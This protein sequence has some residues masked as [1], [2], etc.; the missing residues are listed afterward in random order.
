MQFLVINRRRTEQ[1][2]D[3]EF[4]RVIPA[5]T[6]RVRVL[7]AAGIIRQAWLRGDVSGA[8][9]ILEAVDEADAR[10]V[11]SHLPLATEDLSDFTVI[12]LL[13]YRGFGPH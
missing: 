9:F 12:P 1:Y 8:C 13:P 10:G 4:E 6:D 3:A 5:E 2:D 11:A 7:Y